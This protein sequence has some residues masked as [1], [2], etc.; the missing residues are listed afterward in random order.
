[1]GQLYRVSNGASAAAAAPVKV[2]T[3]TAI[4]TMLQLVHPTLPIVVVEWGVSMDG[5]ALATPGEWELCHTTTVA[6]TVT[7]YA[8]NDVTLVT[9]PL[10]AT[11]GLTLGTAASGYTSTAEGTVVAPVRSGDLQLIQ[12][13]NQY[14]HQW[15]LGQE[16]QVPALGILR[17]RCT[18]AVA[19]NAYCYVVFG[20]G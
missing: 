13:T 6:S 17:V 9:D 16:F 15:P 19:V 20:I 18:T 10:G 2:T 11:P 12:P 4:K 5:T 7:A 1:M 8:A 14:L 3:G